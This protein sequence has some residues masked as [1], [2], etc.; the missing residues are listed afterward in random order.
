MRRLYPVFS[1][2]MVALTT[3]SGYE[4]QAKNTSSPTFVIVAASFNN[5]RWCQKHL[6]SIFNQ[7]YQNFKLIYIDDCS[8]DGTAQEVC[9]IVSQKKQE[10]RS[11][12]IENKTRRLKMANFYDA[13]HAHCS[14]SDI[15]VELDADDWFADETVLSYLAT[16]YADPNIWM[17]Y[18]Q[19]ELFP[20]GQKGVC[21]QVPKNIIDANNWRGYHWATSAL[22]TFYAGLF[23]RIKKEDLQHNGVFLSMTADQGF[24][25]PMLE[26][27]QHHTKFIDKVLYIYNRVTAINDDKVSRAQQ[28]SWERIVRSKHRYAPLAVAPWHS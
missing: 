21:H 12:I 3:F 10:H 5:S 16:I 15:I 22:R 26:M 13:I 23:K 27:A 28:V 11:I 9:K 25:F 17:T 6:D 14:D 2:F 7:T 8:T 18:G 19:Y 4:L 24:M 20:S 1:L